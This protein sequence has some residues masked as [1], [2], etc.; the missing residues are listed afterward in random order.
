MTDGPETR[1]P[2]PG[3]VRVHLLPVTDDAVADA[4]RE[5]QVLS[6]DERERAA[7]FRRPEDR[8]LYEVAHV[9]LRR[10]VAPLVGVAPEDLR[11]G[12]APCPHCG[13]PHGRPVLPQAPGLHVSLSHTAGLAA[14]AIA[15]DPVGVDVEPRDRDA[16]HLEHLAPQLHPDERR[17][18]A[19][20]PDRRA[21]LLRCWVRKEAAMKGRGIGLAEP[22]HEH[23]VAWPGTHGISTDGWHVLDLDAG[24]GYV[25]AVAVLRS[26]SARAPGVRVA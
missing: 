19:T 16:A 4:T 3:E 15:R 22:L 5:S 7:A 21:T 2:S 23:S 24:E 20:A 8:A 1:W 12:A 25:G 6:P 18:I 9:G 17:W 13:G 11:L 14:I 26:V 10:I